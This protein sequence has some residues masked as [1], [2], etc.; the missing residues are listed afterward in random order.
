MKNWLEISIPIK[1][2]TVEERFRKDSGDITGLAKSINEIGL[3]NPISVR[4]VKEG[5]KLLAGRRRIAAC[6]SLGWAEIPARVLEGSDFNWWILRGPN[7]F[8]VICEICDYPIV[9]EHHIIPRGI[10][11]IDED[12]NKMNVCPNHHHLLDW[13]IKIV[14]FLSCP[15][16]PEYSK[17]KEKIYIKMLHKLQVADPKGVLYFERI[18]GPKLPDLIDWEGPP[19]NVS[20]DSLRQVARD[21]QARLNSPE[22]SWRRKV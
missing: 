9:E 7:H 14:M 5:F 11:G 21:I 13:M 1:K 6:E 4:K 20:Y 16:S 12:Y 15:D 3:L 19:P 2:I 22:D 18:I 10:G 8:D 17:R